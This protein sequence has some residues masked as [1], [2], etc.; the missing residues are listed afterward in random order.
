[1]L[2]PKSFFSKSLVTSIATLMSGSVLAQFITILAS[3]LMTRLYTEEQI[4]EYTL[5]LTAVSMFGS[6]L[7]GRYDQSIVSEP[8]ERNSYSLI[9][10]CFLL[11]IIVSLVIGIGYAVYYQL[12]EST[13][14]GGGETFFWIFL[15][16][17]LTG[18]GNILNAYNNRLRQYK[19]MATTHV[20]RT[21]WKEASLVGLGILKTGYYGLLVS[22]SLGVGI[23]LSTQAKKLIQDR[24]KLRSITGKDMKIVARHHIRQPLFSV[25]ASFA[26]SFSYSVLNIFVSNLF[27]NAVLAH[28]SMSF[29]MLGLPLVLISSNMSR[30]FF[31]RASREYDQKGEFH[32]TFLQTSVLLAAIAVP[33]VILLVLFAPWAFEMFFGEGWGKAGVYVRY[34]APMFG[35]RLITSALSSAMTIC[36]KQHI[37][38]YLQGFFVV[39][40]YVVYFLCRDG[41]TME[42]FL[43]GISTMFSVIYIVYYLVMLKMSN[44]V[45]KGE[46]KDG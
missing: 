46:E 6:V 7:C 34:L 12:E 14:L 44:S 40:A 39:S 4:G 27:G 10:L 23:G 26:N 17:L 15:L 45:R 2:N 1:M 43:I 16:L 28:Y 32:R 24:E 22:Q 29:R 36:N 3:P 38:L 25:P 19:V 9:K 35:I 13:S 30:T 42:A 37:E 20:M 18:V 21:A 41:A 8:D 33:M 5:V 11:T 31:E